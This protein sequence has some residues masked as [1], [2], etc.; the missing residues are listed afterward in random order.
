[1]L[2]LKTT[3][4]ASGANCYT[5]QFEV[6]SLGV[7]QAVPLYVVTNGA[8]TQ[9]KFVTLTPNAGDIWRLQ[10][11]G[12]TLKVYQNGVI[13]SGFTTTDTTWASGSPGIQLY[14]DQAIA[15]S[16]ISGWAGGSSAVIPLPPPLASGQVGA[17]CIGP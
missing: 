15:N 6:A 9:L 13:I 17:F 2:P 3:S 7:S 12:T 5:I 1:V 16:T 11:S 4:G 10:M 14:N 8:A